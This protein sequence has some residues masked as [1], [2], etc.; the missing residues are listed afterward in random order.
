MIN[1]VDLDGSGQIEFD[2]FL[3]IIQ[4][5]AGDEKTAK[6]KTFFTELAKRDLKN[7]GL[8]FSMVVLK[9]RKESMMNAILSKDPELKE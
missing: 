4:K 1:S 5:S 3:Q 6:I 7:E 9:I 2:E 8:S